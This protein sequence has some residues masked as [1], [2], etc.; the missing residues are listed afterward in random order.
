MTTLFG[1]FYRRHRGLAIAILL[2]ILAF[3]LVMTKLFF[4]LDSSG[5][6]RFCGFLFLGF[7][8]FL[9]VTGWKK[10]DASSKEKAESRPTSRSYQQLLDEV[11]R[12][13]QE[14][15]DQQRWAF[16]YLIMGWLI[17]STG[18]WSGHPPYNHPLF[19]IP[20]FGIVF[21]AA[22]RSWEK[23]NELDVTIAKCTIEGIVLE[24]KRSG[25]KSSYF[26]DLANRYEGSG[27]WQFAFIRVSP[28]LMII[29]S[30]L[31]GGPLSFLADYL[32]AP[33]WVMHCGS[34]V[35]LGLSWLFF[36]RMACQPY[37]WLLE[38]KNAV[39]KQVVSI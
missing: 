1:H 17:L 11:D 4:S 3:A 9:S 30:L 32:C 8:V 38:K 15:K 20:V 31:N 22:S 19:A 24:K 39:D 27:M 36:E 34:G 23:E 21:L 7:G 12:C 14:L 25:L 33:S 28:F 29:Y 16:A 37:H 10:Q 35:V 5:K 6:G 26:H 18:K 13:F 2:A